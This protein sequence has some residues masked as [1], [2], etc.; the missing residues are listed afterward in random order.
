MY[1]CSHRC[2]GYNY[3]LGKWKKQRW[4]R[5]GLPECAVCLHLQNPGEGSRAH[6]ALP[7]PATLQMESLSPQD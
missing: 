3:I 2:V 5:L 4:A 1:M 6:V 7:T